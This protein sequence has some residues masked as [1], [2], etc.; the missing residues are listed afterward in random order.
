MRELDF[1]PPAYKQARRQ[2]RTMLLQCYVAIAL[3]LA[4]LAGTMLPEAFSHSHSVSNH[5]AREPRRATPPPATDS[6]PTSLDDTT[7]T[8]DAP[9]GQ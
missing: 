9:S 2:R 1:L 4:V 3:G 5:K 7:A 6:S 8:T